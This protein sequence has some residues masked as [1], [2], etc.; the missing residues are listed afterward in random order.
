MLF[1]LRHADTLIYLIASD[2]G[3]KIIYGFELGLALLVFAAALLMRLPPEGEGANFTGQPPD[4][5]FAFQEKRF[6]ITGIIN[7]KSEVE[8]HYSGVFQR[9]APKRGPRSEA[10]GRAARPASFVE[11][12]PVICADNHRGK[13]V[14]AASIGG[15]AEYD[16]AM[17]GS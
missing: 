6:R 2:G 16:R 12:G 1:R 15:T 14:P 8:K 13:R 7:I 5:R 9:H 3:P 10:C 4:R 11:G 17:R